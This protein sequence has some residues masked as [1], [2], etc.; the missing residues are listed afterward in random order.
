LAYAGWSP[1]FGSTMSGCTSEC[2]FIPLKQ[3]QWDGIEKG[4]YE[5]SPVGVAQFTKVSKL[6]IT[7]R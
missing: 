3:L 6:G 5:E 7:M 1:A 4:V 2:L